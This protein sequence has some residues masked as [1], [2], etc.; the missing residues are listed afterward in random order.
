M[1]FMKLWAEAKP[2][3]AAWTERLLALNPWARELTINNNDEGFTAARRKATHERH[4]QGPEAWNQWSSGMLA[5]KKEFERVAKRAENEQTWLALSST[6]FSTQSQPYN[7]ESD[8]DA[9]GHKFPGSARFEG[10]TFSGNATFDSAIFAGYAD[11]EGATFSGSADFDGTIFSGNADFDAAAFSD[12]ASFDRAAFADAAWFRSTEFFGPAWFLGSKFSADVQFDSAAFSRLA[13]F[14]NTQFSR[15]SSFTDAKFSSEVSFD[16][17]KFI[18]NSWFDNTVFSRDISFEDATF[19]DRAVFRRVKFQGDAE[20]RRAT[21]SGLALFDVME[22]AATF[23]LADTA[24]RQVPSLSGATLRGPLRLDNVS[25]PR[26]R[27]LS[28]NFR[29]RTPQLASGN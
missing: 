17:V 16:N 25:T 3:E 15:T 5:Y 14:D 24:F 9:A 13:V 29:I 26:Y 7:F 11:F 6:V 28:S 27:L 8:F 1:N 4:A 18:G 12:A 2:D 20:F 19:L 22:S 21:F 10:A 23:S